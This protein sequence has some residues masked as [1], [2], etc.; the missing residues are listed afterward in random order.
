MP[1]APTRLTS[2]SALFPRP[3]TGPVTDF[4]TGS[5]WRSRR[6]SKRIADGKCAGI[7]V[8]NERCTYVLHRLNFRIDQCSHHPPP[9]KIR[10]CF[11]VMRIFRGIKPSGTGAEFDIN[12]A[13][14]DCG[15]EYPMP[16]YQ[17]NRLRRHYLADLVT[18]HSAIYQSIIAYSYETSSRLI[19][20]A[21][22]T[23]RTC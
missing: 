7:I 4:R 21:T 6:R 9:D 15:G 10:A 16:L 14:R 23:Y 12:V 2:S 5:S 22:A 1:L 3:P 20:N 18:R 19:L 13:G 11:A 8:R 17:N